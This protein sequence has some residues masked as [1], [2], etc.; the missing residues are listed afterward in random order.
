MQDELSRWDAIRY[1][2]DRDDVATLYDDYNVAGFLAARRAAEQERMATMRNHLLGSGVLLTRMLSPR[3]CGIVSQVTEKLELSG[4]FDVICVRDQDINAFAAV[5]VSKEGLDQFIGITSGALELLDDSEIASLIGHEIGHFLFSHNALHGLINRD[6]NNSSLT[7]LPYLGESLFLKWQ[8]KGEISADRV[9]AVASGSFE[10]S[11]RAL[12]KAGFGL[13][14]KNLNLNIEALLQQIESIKD[15]PESVESAF[16]SHPLL[17][18][19]L[20]ALHLFDQAIKEG[21]ADL[22]GVDQEVDGLFGWFRRYPRKPLHEAVMR[23]VAI[24]GMHIIGTDKALGHDETRSLIYVL[25]RYFTDDPERELVLDATEKR[26]RW[27]AAL[28]L[29]ADEGDEDDHG[30]ILSR[31]ADVAIADGRLMN[32]ESG[33]IL[34]V[35]E[36]MGVKPERAYRIMVGAAQTTGF[37]TD[38]RMQNIVKHVRNQYA[39]SLIDV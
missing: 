32:E 37:N 38:A 26:S 17:P 21:V 25:H 35:A 22:R 30:F 14:E 29:L 2:G 24:A 19:R 13:S 16:R 9:G 34:N 4:A 7:V 27:D 10:A 8:K 23:I 31:L 1:A 39:E 3:V 11:A 36:M 28:K 33:Y 20:K 5:D 6:D 18:L 15:N 12:V